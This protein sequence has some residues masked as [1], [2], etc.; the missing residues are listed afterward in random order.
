MAEAA[1]SD[2]DETVRELRKCGWLTAEEE[3]AGKPANKGAGK[4][5]SRQ[6]RAWMVLCLHDDTSAHLEGYPNQ[7]A[8][9][10]H[11]PTVQWP[12]E[13][14]VHVAVAIALDEQQQQHPFTITLKERTLVF[15]AESREQMVEWIDALRN[16]LKELG[17]L[18]PS[19]NLYSKEPEVRSPLA[20]W[21]DPTSPLPPTPNL[22]SLP[23]TAEFHL[24]TTPLLE[25][26]LLSGPAS[27]AS[28]LTANIHD[29][30]LPSPRSAPVLSSEAN[31]FDFSS[32]NVFSFGDPRPTDNSP[33]EPS[34]RQS[35]LAGEPSPLYEPLYLAQTPHANAA[36][37]AA[38][39]NAVAADLTQLAQSHDNDEQDS[40][41]QEAPAPVSED[42][43][44]T[45]LTL[46]LVQVL[47]LRREIEHRGGVRIKVRLKDC[48]G[49]IA[50]VD[51][52]GAVWIAGWKQREHPFLYNNFH[53]G[54]QVVSIAHNRILTAHE[55]YRVIKHSYTPSI[56]FIILR[57][58]FGKALALRRDF[59]FQ[60]LG[61]D[62]EENSAEIKRVHPDGLVARNGLTAKSKS[63][64]SD[65]FCNWM[66]TE[67]NGRPL[68]LFCKDAEVE[69][70]LN[71]VGKDISLL[72]QPADFVRVL[73]KQLKSLRSYKDFIVH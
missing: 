5:K 31:H 2:S 10:A 59:E 43:P 70:R 30:S 44:T 27:P 39:Q 6:E 21:R 69:T 1:V 18:Q 16:A 62:R 22:A 60:S 46:K 52:L 42:L 61:F 29:L 11:K 9:N 72:V 71:A 67:I 48:V 68:H 23:S 19:A 25:S 15:S 8:V 55:A 37:D 63:P 65:S 20:P 53:I 41:N 12:L 56:E 14:C 54:D 17:I 45:G 50:F 32:R 64:V 13:N 35:Q 49:S 40:S 51:I 57:L 3:V 26:G 38:A 47:Q 34:Q 36:V 4:Q 58:P 73:K 24:R 28:S 66:L 33:E 7:K